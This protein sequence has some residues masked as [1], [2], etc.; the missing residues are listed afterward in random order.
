[1]NMN[2]T[3]L[4][5]WIS[6]NK[7]SPGNTSVAFQLTI[8]AEAYFLCPNLTYQIFLITSNRECE[9]PI[10]SLQFIDFCGDI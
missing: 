6:I 10:E 8:Y 3:S 1:M 4:Y 2:F 7:K 9:T 5:G